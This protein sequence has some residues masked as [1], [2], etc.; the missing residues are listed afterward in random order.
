MIITHPRIAP[1]LV[2]NQHIILLFLNSQIL[3][4]GS[5][6]VAKCVTITQFWQRI[7]LAW[8]ISS[9]L[10]VGQG[11]ITV[12]SPTRIRLRSNPLLCS[13]KVSHCH[14]VSRS[15]YVYSSSLVTLRYPLDRPADEQ[16]HVGHYGFGDSAQCRA[17]LYPLRGCPA[18]VRYS[19]HSPFHLVRQNHDLCHTGI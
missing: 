1:H 12:S 19:G 5:M 14:N 18:D 7:H 11:S 3:G 2:W 10:I 9:L 4:A 8:S 16:P 15:V 6:M 13:I 17:P